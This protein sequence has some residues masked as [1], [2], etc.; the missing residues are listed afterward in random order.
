M[1]LS[2]NLSAREKDVWVNLFVDFA[3]AVYYLPRALVLLGQSDAV[4]LRAFGSL[5]GS[6]IAVAVVLAI[7]A[8][9]L[10]KAYTSPEPRD[11]R[12]YLFEARANRSALAVLNVGLVL[13]LG[14][15]VA[16]AFLSGE[17]AWVGPSMPSLVMAHYVLVAMWVADIL[18]G[19][20]LVFSYRRGY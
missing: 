18:R 16:G 13:L 20:V 7:A 6:T 15:L 9:C 17:S 11:E 8:T 12:D 4:S 3:V 19:V 14:Q 1:G 5:I 2:A 10:L